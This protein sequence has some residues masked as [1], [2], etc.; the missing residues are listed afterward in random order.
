MAEEIAVEN[1]R[2]SN[3]EELVTSTLDR[4]ILHAVVHH[5]SP[6]TYTP[7]FIEI[8][9]SFCGRTDIRTYVHTYAWTNER[10]FETGFGVDLTITKKQTTKMTTHDM[11]EKHDDVQNPR[12]HGNSH[13]Y[14]L[15]STCTA[16][17]WQCP[18]YSEV[19]AQLS[20]KDHATCYVSWNLVNCCTTVRKILYENIWYRRVILNVNQIISVSSLQ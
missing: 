1:G 3:S 5:S 9:E 8:E 11:V 13:T 20:Y 17:H 4:V 19:E 14:I 6:S 10:A 7:N 12:T 18:T 15:Q 2:I 16:R